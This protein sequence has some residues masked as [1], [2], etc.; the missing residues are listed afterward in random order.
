M[1]NKELFEVCEGLESKGTDSMLCSLL[2][3]SLGD[4]E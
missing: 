2:P 3:M 1:F 4:V